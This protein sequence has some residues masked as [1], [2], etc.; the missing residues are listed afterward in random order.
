MKC[1]H[2]GSDLTQG[3]K[4]CAECGTKVQLQSTQV[5]VKQKAGTVEDA[6]TGAVVGEGA[7]QG[8]G[9]DVSVGQEAETVKG[10]MTGAVLGVT[11][12]MHFGKKVEGDE[13]HGD[14]TKISDAENVIVGDHGQITQ[15]LSAEEIAK[16]FAPVHQKIE[17]VAAD[18][19]DKEEMKETVQKIEK[20]VA[21]GEEANPTKVERWLGFL[22]DISGDV[23]DVAAATLASPTAG[24][25]MVIKKVAEKAKDE[26]T[27]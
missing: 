26:A 16:L 27:S 22:G 2:C 19:D 12:P 25:A 1:S 20:E 14:Q 5:D 23:L 11:G 8:G 24:V 18:P 3:A 21:K 4:F 7:M 9:V 10:P 15:G 17:K 6:I 13:V